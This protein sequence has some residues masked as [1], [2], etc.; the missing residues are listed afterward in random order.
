MQHQLLDI[1]QAGKNF[2]FNNLIPD[3][4]ICKSRSLLHVTMQT[5][6]LSGG[7]WSWTH[8]CSG[9]N[10]QCQHELL[11]QLHLATRRSGR[12]ASAPVLS[13]LSLFCFQAR[14]CHRRILRSE[15]GNSRCLSGVST[16]HKHLIVD[17]LSFC[18]SISQTHYVVR[19]KHAGFIANFLSDPAV[20]K[21]SPPWWRR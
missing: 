13:G 12:C 14:Y 9:W 10:G 7:V 18:C 2:L 8:S 20:L 1:L 15:P 16:G 4:S 6:C 17:S 5:R 19:W 21:S 3:V 11:V